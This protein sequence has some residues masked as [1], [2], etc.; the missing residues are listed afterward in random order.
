[1]AGTFRWNGYSPK[2]ETPWGDVEFTA[3]GGE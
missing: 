3:S 2:G 1:M